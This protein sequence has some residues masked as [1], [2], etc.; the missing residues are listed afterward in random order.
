LI[1]TG[2]GPEYEC[3]RA[4]HGGPWIFRLST[5]HLE[6][7]ICA[8]RRGGAPTWRNIILAGIAILY[9]FTGRGEW[10]RIARKHLGWYAVC[11][12]TAQVPW[13]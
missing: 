5:V 2:G 7:G 1:S 4:S 6:E 10:V 11:W 9:F 13:I 12:M 3:G 8:P